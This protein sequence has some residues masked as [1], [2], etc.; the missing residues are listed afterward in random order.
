M[1]SAFHYLD[2]QNGKTIDNLRLIVFYFWKH[3]KRTSK[4]SKFFFSTLDVIDQF[5]KN[6]K[7]WIKVKKVNRA[8]M[9]R[10]LSDGRMLNSFKITYSVNLVT[11]LVKLL[12]YS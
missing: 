6:I 8:V 4:C 2:L 3:F 12:A 9:E 10:Y 7:V 5:D 1:F 11:L